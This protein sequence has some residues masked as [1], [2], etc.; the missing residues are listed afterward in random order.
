MGRHRRSLPPP[1]G[2]GGYEFEV[3]V[4]GPPTHFSDPPAAKAKGG[5]IPV[6]DGAGLPA[7]LAPQPDDRT[8][9]ELSFDTAFQLAV[10]RHARQDDS[11]A[12]SLVERAIGLARRSG[13][14]HRT[15]IGL[16]LQ[17]KLLSGLGRLAEAAERT[18]EVV[19]IAEEV[20][21][22]R[23]LSSALVNYGELLRHLG[24][25][26]EADAVLSRALTMAE[27]RQ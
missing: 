16:H 19:R 23:L 8:A 24:R 1:P 14:R 9:D 18:E 15:A 17:G 3:I 27:Q 6:G 5:L 26:D 22:Q 21:D 2:K 7:R 4:P 10:T 13:D 12:L 25:L 20:A 11:S